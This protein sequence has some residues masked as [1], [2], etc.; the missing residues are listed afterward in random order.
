[1]WQNQY[2]LFGPEARL[3]VSSLHFVA[4]TQ[5]T[6]LFLSPASARPASFVF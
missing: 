4:L 2:F 6:D 5:F 3:H 1:M